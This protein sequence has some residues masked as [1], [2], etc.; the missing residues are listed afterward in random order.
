MAVEG[1]SKGF[2]AS[3]PTLR[4]V[5]ENIDPKLRAVLLPFSIRHPR[6]FWAYGKLMRGY[7]RARKVRKENRGQGLMVPPF[8]ILSMTSRCNLQCAGCYAAAA[9]IVPEHSTSDLTLVQ[10]RSI[11]SQASELG[12]FGFILGGGE[13]FLYPGLLD[14]CAE[15]DDRVF[16]IVTNGT[17]LTEEHFES[18][19]RISNV[20][21]V[22]SI[23]GDRAVTDARRGKGVHG[24][25]MSTLKR[26]GK[27]GVISGISVTITQRNLRYWMAERNIDRLIDQGVLLG[28]FIEQIPTDG[29][30]S[31]GPCG[32]SPL[33][34]TKEERAKFRNCMLAY[35]EKKPIYI[36]HSPGDEELFGGCVSAGRGFAHV[37]PS[38]D[39]TPCPVSDVATHNLTKGSLRDGLAS[40][41]FKEI[42]E[43]E[44]LLETG[45]TPCALFAHPK[46]LDEL[47]S[48]LGAYHAGRDRT[49]SERST[50]PKRNGPT[51]P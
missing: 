48:R 28:V 11:I 30:T 15:F 36:V 32:G 33:M 31:L 35:R 12:T 25:A 7:E 1:S 9:G 42:R 38:G 41:L 8:M 39:L 49:Q 47:A 16:I 51:G 17:T 20:C 27:M 3:E 23:E 24:K 6:R 22:V 40:P 19:K 37:T 44:H 13:P 46:E 26:L 45:E 18:L 4:Q 50:R 10:W 43:C 14:I 34:L 5:L 21:I 29:G 2:L